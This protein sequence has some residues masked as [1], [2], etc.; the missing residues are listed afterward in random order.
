MANVDPNAVMRRLRVRPMLLLSLGALAC[1][2]NSTGPDDQDDQDG[3][4]RS[5]SGTVTLS[6]AFASQAVVLGE[7]PDNTSANSGDTV[8]VIIAGTTIGNTI[9]LAGGATSRAYDYQLPDDPATFGDLIAYI[10]LDGNGIPD[11]STEPVRVAV[12]QIE[13]VDRIVDAWS[14]AS[15]GNNPREY[16]VSVASSLWSIDLIGTTGFNFTF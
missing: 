7:I 5:V 14:W 4:A 2:G 13:G 12:K 6:A 15:F 10:D 1:G 9:T 16:M 3:P 11:P 8:T